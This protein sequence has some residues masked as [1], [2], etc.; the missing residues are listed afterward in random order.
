MKSNLTFKNTTAMLTLSP[1]LKGTKF[2]EIKHIIN[3]WKG[4]KALSADSIPDYWSSTKVAK[5]LSLL[6]NF[7][8]DHDGI[9]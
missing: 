2:Y 4:G 7:W 6:L 1:T 8:L 5:N 9:P 3:S